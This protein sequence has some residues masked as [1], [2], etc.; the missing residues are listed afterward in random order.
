MASKLS[1][2]TLLVVFS[3]S[4]IVLPVGGFFMSKAIVFEGEGETRMFSY[5][6][7]F[8]LAS[9]PGTRKMGRVGE[10]PL[11]FKLLSHFSRERGYV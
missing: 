3:L 11:F 7:L 4:M 5:F 6:E 2:I 9:F 1:P 8:D 10:E